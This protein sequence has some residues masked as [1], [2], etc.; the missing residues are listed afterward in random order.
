[1]APRTTSVETG[2]RKRADEYG[3]G[4]G[5]G[6]TICSISLGHNLTVKR[7]MATQMHLDDALYLLQLTD[8]GAITPRDIERAFRR[9]ARNVHPDAGGSRTDW[10]ALKEAQQV[11][12]HHYDEVG[13]ELEVQTLRELVRANRSA[14][15][16]AQRREETA[17]TK[18]AVVRR[19]TSSLI[20]ARRLTW[21]FTTAS[22]IALALYK[23]LEAFAAA[24]G[25]PEATP[26]FLFDAQTIFFS[27]SISIIGLIGLLF[28]IRADRIAQAVEDLTA[29]L[30][31]HEV[32]SQLKDE[33]DQY[34]GV[35]EGAWWSVGQLEGK[36]GRW[37][38]PRL[39]GLSG[40]DLIRAP[41]EL[42]LHLF[43]APS[44]AAIGRRIGDRDATR[45][46]LRKGLE[47][48]AIRSSRESLGLYA[49]SQRA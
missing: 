3:Q 44:L 11:A 45:I 28:K 26:S 19:R 20:K 48:G 30:G 39:S 18:H 33:I 35:D 34:G 9:Q 13:A 41:F 46:V 37:I 49:W 36:V 8:D 32:Y 24:G 16:L 10:D 27:L 12:L 5:L 6:V 1:M 29:E 21:G 25:D 22:A 17:D 15:E 23:L 42:R 38:N 7:Q 31:D 14:L 2:Q 40:P 47:I 43:G 4:V